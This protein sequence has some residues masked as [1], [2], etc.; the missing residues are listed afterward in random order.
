[1]LPSAVHLSLGNADLRLAL[2]RLCAISGVESSSIEYPDHV[3][4]QGEVAARLILDPSTAPEGEPAARFVERMVRRYSSVLALV[5]EG[6]DEAALLK[7]GVAEVFH[8]GSPAELILKRLRAVEH[9]NGEQGARPA[10]SYVLEHFHSSVGVQLERARERERPLVI[11]CVQEE[12]GGAADFAASVQLAVQEQSEALEDARE[13][14][15]AHSRMILSEFEDGSV[16][17]CVPSIH[18][19]HD[20]ALLGKRLQSSLVS[21][22]GGECRVGI[23]CSPDDGVDPVEITQRARAAASRNGGHGA[24]KINFFTESMGRWAF[25]RLA[26]ETSLRSALHNGEIT[27]F[28]QPRVDME[29]RAMN[30][31][32]A[33]VRWNHPTFGLVSPAQFIPIAEETGLIVPIGEWVLREAC[34]QNAEWRAEGIAPIRVSVNLSSIQFRSANLEETV[35]SALEDSGLPPDGLELEVT[36]SLLMDDPKAAAAILGRLQSRGVHVSIDD[37]GTG[38]SSLAYLKSFPVNSLKIDRTFISDVTGNPND[39]AITTAII[40]MGHSMNLKVVA[41]GVE[42][43]SQMA[44][45]KVLQCNEVQGYFFSPPVPTDRARELLLGDHAPLPARRA[46]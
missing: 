34:R 33:L 18:Q 28:Y 10:G 9:P 42:T 19:V 36:E 41:E 5:T 39:A 45:L 7:M 23:S 37:F 16:V 38:Y 46:A 43:E 27:V 2:E 29:S 44:F 13:A 15:F 40:L 20:A 6:L 30:G 25:E 3:G 12:A 1:M 31:M 14:S 35:A 8:P 4:S 17:F 26:L 32:E 11:F 22:R 21:K 24:S